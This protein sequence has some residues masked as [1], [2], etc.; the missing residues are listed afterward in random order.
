M[1]SL[2]INLICSLINDIVVCF[3]KIKISFFLFVV[4]KGIPELSDC[5]NKA[6]KEC[7][8]ILMEVHVNK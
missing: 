5:L 6:V 1:E 8:D 7:E 3:C 2:E 4:D